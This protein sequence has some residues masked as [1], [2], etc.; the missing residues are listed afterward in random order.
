MKLSLPM[1]ELEQHA[2]HSLLFNF[3]LNIFSILI[4][5]FCENARNLDVIYLFQ[6]VYWRVVFGPTLKQ[7]TLQL[8]QNP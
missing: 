3:T 2:M 5:D 1:E 6:H 4:Y 7:Q 8:L